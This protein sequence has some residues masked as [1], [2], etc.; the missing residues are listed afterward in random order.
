MEKLNLPVYSFR[1]SRSSREILL[2]FDPIRKKNVVL[3][4]EE[5]VRQNIIRYLT[6]E[7]KFPAPLI[8]MEAGI[9]VNR[10]ARRYDALVFDR[11]GKALVLIECKAPSVSIQQETFDQVAA[12]NTS[13]RANYLLITNGMKH[14]FCKVIAA[15][16]KYDFKG[17]I[18]AFDEL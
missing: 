11:F 12:Y 9:K 6:E 16:Q 2:I 15:K 5:W 13:I 4:P 14:Y 18:P 17:D 1:I 3:S 8:S 10:L 7:K